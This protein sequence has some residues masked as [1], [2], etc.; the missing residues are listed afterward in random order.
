LAF[1]TIV[2]AIPVERSEIVRASENEAADCPVNVSDE[3]SSMDP[4]T[5]NAVVVGHA[6]VG[7]VEGL[8]PTHKVG[9]AVCVAVAVA[10]ILEVGLKDEVD[11]AAED[12]DVNA[13]ADGVIE[14]VAEA[15]LDTVVVP[16]GECEAVA[17][18][19]SLELA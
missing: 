18:P 8:S 12:N 11:V 3:A 5:G 17:V 16:S 13:E 1:W 10:D 14:T 4:A 9:G 7:V 15:E 6:A 19:D 2:F